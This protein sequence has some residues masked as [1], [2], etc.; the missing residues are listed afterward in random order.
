MMETL[1]PSLFHSSGDL[2]D[3]TKVISFSRVITLKNSDDGH[4]HAFLVT[5]DGA[6][7]K[8]GQIWLTYKSEEG[9]KN[10]RRAFY[11]MIQAANGLSTS[12]SEQ[13][14]ESAVAE[15]GTEQVCS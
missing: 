9:A 3:L 2:I 10:A 7:G 6:P 13:P 15:C 14:V 4:T 12:E 1:K 8:D 11:G 5:V